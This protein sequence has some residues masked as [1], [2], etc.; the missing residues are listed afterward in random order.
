MKTTRLFIILFLLFANEVFAQKKIYG[1]I[2][3]VNGN[4]ISDVNVL[5]LSIDS[6]LL[7]DFSITNEKGY[8]S[9]NLPKKAKFCIIN[10]KTLY[11]KTVYRYIENSEQKIDFKLQKRENRLKEVI[12]KSDPIFKQGDTI[13]YIV[14]AF[15]TQEDR[16]LADVLEKM[17]GIE[18]GSN[19]QVTY[20]GKPIEKYYIDGLDLLEGNYNIANK[21]I[22]HQAVSTVQVLENHQSVK[23]FKDFFSSNSV[24][25]NIKLKKKTTFASTVNLSAGIPFLLHDINIT[26]MLFT[27]KQQML[28]SYQSSNTGNDIQN[29]LKSLSINDFVNSVENH[30]YLDNFFYNENSTPF[31]ETSE[32]YLFNNSHIGSVN[33]LARLKND[34]HL[35][36]NASYYTDKTQI[37]RTNSNYYYFDN[38]TI[39]IEEDLQREIFTD[40]FNAKFTIYSNRNKGYLKNVFDI[41]FENTQQNDE[42]LVNNESFRQSF[43]IPFLSFSNRFHLIKPVGRK[44]ISF[45]SF[46]NYNESPQH[47]NIDQG[48][49]NQLINNSTN[50]GFV[51]N[52]KLTVLNSNNYIEMSHRIKNSIFSFRGGMKYQTK[53]TFTNIYEKQ[54]AIL[55]E[56]DTEFQNKVNVGGEKYYIE[57]KQQYNRRKLKFDFN[58]PFVYQKI[59]NKNG[60]NN[61]S[62]TANHLFI[63]PEAY[64]EYKAFEKIKLRGSF[65]YKKNFETSNTNT[66]Y[67]LRNYNFINRGV[68][69]IDL[70]KKSYSGKLNITYESPVYSFFVTGGYYFSKLLTDYLIQSYQQTSG[71]IINEIVPIPNNTSANT[72]Y[73]RTSKFFPKTKTTIFLNLNHS[74]KEQTNYINEVVLLSETN[75][76]T[77]NPKIYIQISKKMRLE[78]KSKI[79]YSMANLTNNNLFSYLQNEY[80]TTIKYYPSKK[81]YLS[82]T[83]D[84]HNN[85]AINSDYFF[86]DAKYQ[87]SYKY[88]DFELK[89]RNI[90]N[91][92]E[93][94]SYTTNQNYVNYQT[95]LLR[96]SEFLFSVKFS[97][98]KLD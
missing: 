31:F 1:Y 87:F 95:Y 47:L 77:I 48:V 10:I 79:I 74:I 84:Y 75:Q 92:T 12:V 78:L 83:F 7:F 56:L 27:K 94:S 4:A 49:I 45:Y 68:N 98:S 13:N 33:Y 34:I 55:S 18:V 66:G 73:L 44:L 51:Q 28:F 59:Y 14:D 60:I 93:F 72:F 40:N 96:P 85:S 81:Q 5:L 3:D 62:I 58:I 65:N 8:Y 29:D 32:R 16:V 52:A 30:D 71:E 88:I 36:I 35:R 63:Q 17:P 64:I 61:Y 97:I 20:L 15:A 42:L 67:I 41:K 37:D 80:F 25:L 21:N 22:P 53:Q 19:G 23:V 24:S 43:E 46:T 57:L 9:I 6:S 70:E 26:P 76:T 82:L 2:I 91:T 86:I 89:W 90:M 38:D 50:T 69:D 54:G 39:D 11:Y